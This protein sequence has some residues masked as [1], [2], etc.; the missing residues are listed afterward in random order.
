MR[1]GQL[2]RSRR[3]AIWLIAGPPTCR[4]NVWLWPIKGDPTT[5]EWSALKDHQKFGQR[6]CRNEWSVVGED[7][8][9]LYPQATP[10]R[11][12]AQPYGWTCT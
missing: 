9:D 7:V 2:I 1:R 3:G 10:L 11:G 5:P 4:G 12:G 6:A 8:T